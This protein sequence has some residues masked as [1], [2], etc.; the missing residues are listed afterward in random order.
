MKKSRLFFV[1][2]LVGG[3]S[4]IQ[5]MPAWA[6]CHIAAFETTSHEVGEG[7]GSVTL[8]VTLA[9]AAYCEGMV[10]YTTENGSAQAGADF[11]ATQGTLTFMVGDDR[12][13]NIT[14]P[15]LQ[16]SLDEPDETFQV[17]LKDQPGGTIDGEGSPA[18][19]KI[20]DDDEAASSP[21]SQ[22]PSQ[23][24]QSPKASVL[25]SAS[26]TTP[27]ESPSAA[28]VESPPVSPSKSPS[29]PSA[30]GAQEKEGRDRPIGLII[31]AVVVIAGAA[32]A[33][34]WYLRRPHT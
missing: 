34:G 32:A 27:T 12:Q 11:T 9:P 2:L 19:V 17:V 5:S 26:Q 22:T 29:L 1:V 24:K 31:T 6:P 13:E 30:T 18:S 15:I 21:P 28:P 3:W 25:P 16:D 23:S 4:L 33:G 10:D 8:K 14:I 20:K 7:S